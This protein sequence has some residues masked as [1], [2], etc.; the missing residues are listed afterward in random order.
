MSGRGRRRILTPDEV[1]IWRAV[2]DTVTPLPGRAVEGTGDE[3]ETPPAEPAPAPPPPAIPP[4]RPSKTP[5]PARPLPDLRSGVTP[6]LD[7]RSSE[8]MKRGEMEID[9]R[10]DLHGMTQDVAHAALV[11]FVSRAYDGGRRCLLV[12]TGKGYREGT[13]VLRANVPRWLNQ[14]PCRERILGF[15]TARP[16][17]GGEGALYVLIKRRR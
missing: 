4:A 10:L 13:G 6:G 12:I 1:R 11:G 9:G 5:M 2:A 15:S 8:R 3:V 16:Q 14:S 7:K 17:H